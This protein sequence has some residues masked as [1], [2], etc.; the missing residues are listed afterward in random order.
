MRVLCLNQFFDPDESATAQFLTD[1][2]AELLR[3]GHSVEVICGRAVYAQGNARLPESGTLRVHRVGPEGKHRPGVLGKAL[4]YAAFGAAAGRAISS[5]GAFDVLVCLSTPPLLPALAA[6]AS[7]QGSGRLVLWTQD[8]YPEIAETL[9]VLPKIFGPLLRAPMRRAYHAAELLA[10][11]GRHMAERFERDYGVDPGR[12]DVIP[13][14]PPYGAAPHG[15]GEKFRRDRG[16][17]NSFVLLYSGNLGRAHD[18]STFLEAYQRF[19]AAPGAARPILVFAGTGAGR[20][21]VARFAAEHSECPVELLDHQPRE[22]LPELLGAADVHLISQRPEVDG[23]LVPSKLY[24]I[25]GSGRP[26][27]F[28]GTERNEIADVLALAECGC[29]VEPGRAAELAARWRELAG[30]KGMRERMGEAAA[31]LARTRFSREATLERLV[32]A[33]ERVG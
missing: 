10:V 19:C 5:L 12:M 21:Q 9:G 18:V 15:A 25:L 4:D 2:A 23:L 3:R 1:V 27:C 24:G 16:W 31:A 11:P 32:G 14:W 22:S 17:Q 30:D 6:R 13:H 28:V 33:L 7:R 26:F 29:R 8:V 20:A